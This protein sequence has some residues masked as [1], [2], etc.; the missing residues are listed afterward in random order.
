M[1]NNRINACILR[2]KATLIGLTADRAN[3]AALEDDIA[4]LRDEY[5]ANLTRMSGLAQSVLS[6]ELDDATVQKKGA[7]QELRELGERLAGAMQG[8]AASPANLDSDL[9]G[10]VNINRTDFTEADD[11]SF[12][13][14]LHQLLDVSQPFATQLV[15]R[16]FV[17]DDR[18]A[19]EKL[20]ERFERKQVRQR[21]NIVAGSTE[22]KTLL[23]LVRRNTNL[24]K[25]LRTQLKGY[26]NSPTKHEVWQRFISYTKL[27][28]HNGGGG[29]GPKQA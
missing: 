11:T 16:E 17:A 25:L 13:A 20:L 23:A 3:Y 14:L 6:A 8:Y 4:P 2:D 22:R 29:A 27:V 28:P 12:A 15:K 26:K 24:I 7:R 10:K 18:A 21:E 9:A 19:M 5:G 1:E